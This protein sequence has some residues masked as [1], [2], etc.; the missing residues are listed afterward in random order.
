MSDQ[1][2]FEGLLID[3]KRIASADGKTRDI[4]NP[5]NGQVIARVAQATQEDA[6]HAVRVAHARF[7]D[8]AWRRMNSLDRGRLLQRIADRMRDNLDQFRQLESKNGG[9]PT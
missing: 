9:K 4:Y 8:S 7:D 3:G 2:P 6:D 5:A 1:I